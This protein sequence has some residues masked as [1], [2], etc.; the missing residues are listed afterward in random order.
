MNADKNNNKSSHSFLLVLSKG[1]SW[2][3]P[4]KNYI[5]TRVTKLQSFSGNFFSHQINAV[6]NQTV[7][8]LSGHS[9]SV[10]DVTLLLIHTILRRCCSHRCTHGSPFPQSR[11]SLWI[12]WLPLY[13]NKQKWG[14]KKEWTKPK[15]CMKVETDWENECHR[16]TVV[17]TT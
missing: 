14:K 16:E 8:R 15:R 4:S 3:V 12:C 13:K 17:K 6:L 10:F 11:I 7:R 1:C 9:S 5:S 2:K